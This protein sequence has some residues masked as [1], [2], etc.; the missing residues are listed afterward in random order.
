[1]TYFFSH[2]N[3]TFTVLFC[4]LI[5]SS[6]ATARTFNIY[7][8]SD[9]TGHIESARAIEQGVSV[10]FDEIGYQIGDYNFEI[11][12]LDHRGN[13]ARSKYHMNI[14]AKDNDALAYIG[15]LHS[16][17]LIKYREFINQ[18]QILTLVP[19]AAGAPITRYPDPENWVFRLSVDDRK[20]GERMSDFAVHQLSCKKP[21]LL[22]EETPWG[23]SNHLNVSKA[24]L[25]ENISTPDVAWFNWGLNE[26]AA[27]TRVNSLLDKGADCIIMV[28]NAIEGAKLIAAVASAQER[29]VPIISHWGITG[30][31]LTAISETVSNENLELYFIQTCFSFLDDNPSALAARVYQQAKDRYD[32]IDD[33]PASIE[34]P[35]GFIHG[36]D[37]TKVF[38]AAIEQA[39]ATKQSQEGNTDIDKNDVR[40]ALENLVDPVEGLVKTYQQPFSTYSNDNQDAHEALGLD[41]LCMASLGKNGEIRLLEEK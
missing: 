41:D 36:Y 38:I 37:I 39:V 7:I 20:A 31:N 3:R 17:P 12:L 2:L 32:D 16:P 8:D 21:A 26:A 18:A 6:V 19:W 28:S 30:G 40:L 24:M 35:T 4:S 29:K 22:L 33:N 10:A 5:L 13:S 23:K 1:M 9:R 27:R 15:G 34:A 25:N 14:Y 11:I